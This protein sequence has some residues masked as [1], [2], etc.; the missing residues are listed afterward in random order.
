MLFSLGRYITD[1]YFVSRYTFIS[2]T[3]YCTTST[4]TQD[5][6]I[7]LI[8]NSLGELT[9]NIAVVVDNRLSEFKR[10]LED[11]QDETAETSTAKRMKLMQQPLIK[12]GGNKQQF[13]HEL[14][15]LGK[16]EE[17]F[18]ALDQCKYDKG[19][20]VLSEGIELVKFRLKLIPIGDKSECGWKTGTM[21]AAHG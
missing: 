19:K 17:A 15:V 7:P 3:N 9:S 20:E 18:N 21:V 12:S 2:Q 4:E 5:D 1:G 14:N 10:Q 6:H 11:S 8:S 13:Q 16:M